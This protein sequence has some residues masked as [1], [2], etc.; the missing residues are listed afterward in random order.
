MASSGPATARRYDSAMVLERSARPEARRRHG[1]GRERL[2]RDQPS[3]RLEAFVVV[4]LGHEAIDLGEQ[5]VFERRTRNGLGGQSEILALISFMIA[6][7]K[8]ILDAEVELF[9]G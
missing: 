7:Q 1:F 2:G 8:H 9:G 4:G 6:Q 3:E 5:R